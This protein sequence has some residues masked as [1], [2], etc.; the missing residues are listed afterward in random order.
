MSTFQQLST[1]T[2]PLPRFLTLSNMSEKVHWNEGRCLLCSLIY[3]GYSLRHQC[4]WKQVTNQ[5]PSPSTLYSMLSNVSHSFR[6]LIYFKDWGHH[7]PV[8]LEY[9]WVCPDPLACRPREQG[10]SCHHH[11]PK[12]SL[13]V[14][15]SASLKDSWQQKDQFS[16]WQ[17]LPLSSRVSIWIKNTATPNLWKSSQ[18]EWSAQKLC[19]FFTF[20][21]YSMYWN[22][23][24][25][26]C[27]SS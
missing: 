13:F 21:Q 7:Y 12:C 22:N 8:T 16:S 5:S 4:H 27:Y 20:L 19:L 25:L 14:I 15:E 11:F 9:P 24:Y 23:S 26:N 2:C 6:T 3:P 10:E 18:K 1:V 17:N